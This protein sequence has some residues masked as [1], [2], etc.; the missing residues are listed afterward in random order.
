MYDLDFLEDDAILVELSDKVDKLEENLKIGLGCNKPD[1][2][3]VCNRM[4]GG[5][6]KRKSR[7]KRGKGA[8]V[9][10]ISRKKKH[11]SVIEPKKKY[12]DDALE[13]LIKNPEW[14][15]AGVVVQVKMMRDLAFELEQ[16]DKQK[17]GGRRKRKSRKKR[18][19]KRRKSRKRRR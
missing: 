15:R 3:E 18:K 8:V 16:A 6:R 1:S 4:S 2:P 7:K 10:R 19:K 14:I 12:V 9:S 17:K 13:Q 5:K 11:M